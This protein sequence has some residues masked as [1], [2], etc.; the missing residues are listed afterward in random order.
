MPDSP[1]APGTMT[2]PFAS[3]EISPPFSAHW[4]A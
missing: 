1:P 2:N 4:E 3:K